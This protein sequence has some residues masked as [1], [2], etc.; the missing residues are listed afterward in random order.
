MGDEQT[1]Q[2]DLID[3]AIRQAERQLEAK[4]EA[5]RMSALGDISPPK[6]APA[7]DVAVLRPTSPTRAPETPRP[8]GTESAWTESD[9]DDLIFTPTSGAIEGLSEAD[10]FVPADEPQADELPTDLPE[11]AGIFDAAAEPADV[12]EHS[13]ASDVSEHSEPEAPAE[14]QAAAPTGVTFAS[15][16]HDLVPS[17]EDSGDADEDSLPA[18][19]ARQQPESS[20][21]RAA[22]WDIPT[23]T[24][25]AP[26]APSEDEMQFWAH[27]RTALRN[28]Q[29]VTDHLPGQ[30]SDNVVSDLGRIVHEE[31]AVTSNAIRLVQQQVQQGF[32]KLADR[33]EGALEQGIAAPTQ[34][35]RQLRDDLPNQLERTVQDTRD[36]VREDLDQTATNLHGAVQ[37]DVAQLEQSIAANVTR[38]T[39]G[40]TEG[41][42]RVERDV[43]SLSDTVV[44]FERGV[45]SEFDRVEA[46]LRAA[47]EHVEQSVRQDLVEPGVTVRKLEEELPA[48]FNHVESTLLG[49]M[50][51][52]QRELSTVLAGLVD[53]N[54]ASLDRIAS[55]ASTLDEERT[56][57]SE[58]VELMVD[59]V[60][61]GWEGLAGAIKALFL[62]GEETNRRIAEVETSIG[63]VHALE[64]S[65]QKTMAEFQHHMANLTPAPVI[66][67][68]AHPEAE[69]RNTARGGWLPTPSSNE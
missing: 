37:K 16:V 53:A 5:L 50:Q 13:D 58:D 24:A 65:V 45:H 9:G 32:P 59:T 38:M 30:V 48:R 20:I 3:D 68:V 55:I 14:Q 34:S 29:Q 27:T 33:I 47:I 46:Q 64:E 61:T 18:F 2:S 25:A 12:D 51:T 69:V 26:A 11:L 1:P 17:W 40:V 63:N 57:R 23:P 6:T 62:Q 8:A 22:A 43:D 19:L 15:T 31:S 35:L 67:T 7:D 42:G 44:R 10:T 41:V 36:A 49:Q 66:V 28:L 52:T 4:L 39:H 21:S 56:R 54:R 60:T